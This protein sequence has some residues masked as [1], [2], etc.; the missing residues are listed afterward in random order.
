MPSSPKVSVVVPFLNSGK[1]IS[2]SIES[3][4]TQTYTSWELVLIDDG[5]DD[6]STTIAKTF[7]LESR[8]KITYLEHEGH[9]NRGMPASRNLGIRH[10]RGEYIAHL[11]SDD[12]WT[13]DL[14]ADQVAILDRNPAVAMTFGPMKLWAN[15]DTTQRL[16]QDRVQTFTFRADKILYH[17]TFVPLLLTERN[18]PA[19]YLIRRRVLD[20]VGLYEESFE[21]CEDWALYIKIA[22]KYEIFVSS[23]CNYFYRQHSG[24]SCNDLRRSGQFHAQ[25][26]PFF[27]WLKNYL[28]S[29]Q[30]D[31]SEVL[32]AVTRLL[33]RNRFNRVRESA[34]YVARSIF[35][36]LLRNA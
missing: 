1:F 32:S 16:R 22:L 34:C 6:E 15:W 7:A 19:G 2:E 4:L 31:D 25:F 5:S 13:C 17:P 29:I 10:S 20:E 3:V 14:L 12:V 9:K 18:D 21:M 36:P 35:A 26:T 23:K 28:A 27:S 24:Q 33:R 11:D 8:G 30:C